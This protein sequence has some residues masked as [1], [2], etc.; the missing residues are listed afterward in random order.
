MIVFFF[1]VLFFKK[2][3]FFKKT[4]SDYWCSVSA[5]GKKK[6]VC[7]AC[8]NLSFSDYINNVCCFSLIAAVG[9]WATNQKWWCPNKVG[10]SVDSCCYNTV[11]RF[12]AF[13]NKMLKY[14]KKRRYELSDE[15]Y[16]WCEF[17]PKCMQ[18]SHFILESLHPWMSVPE[19]LCLWSVFSSVVEERG[20][21]LQSE[22]EP[23]QPGRV[24]LHHPAPAAGPGVRRPQLST[25]H[26]HGA[27]RSPQATGRWG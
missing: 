7:R 3:L 9:V 13:V 23:Q 11:S 2:L 1:F 5:S 10:T 21:R 27:C 26:R 4:I 22:S 17:Q 8:F 25:S 6:L 15:W 20:E 24:L 18:L 14:R 16:S 12:T 19:S